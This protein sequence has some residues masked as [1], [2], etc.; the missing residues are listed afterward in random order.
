MQ[1]LLLTWGPQVYNTGR[2]LKDFLNVAG[3][4]GLPKPDFAILGWVNL[5]LQWPLLF[6]GGVTA[7]VALAG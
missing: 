6:S 4:H 3:E 2:N 7:V 5:L 1:S